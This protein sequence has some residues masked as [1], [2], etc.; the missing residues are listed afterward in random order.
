MIDDRVAIHRYIFLE[1]IPSK[2]PYCI[3]HQL[4]VI[5]SFINDLLLQ[6]FI[7]A[8]HTDTGLSAPK[9]ISLYFV[10]LSLMAFLSSSFVF[11]QFQQGIFNFTLLS[12]TETSCS[13]IFCNPLFRLKK[14][15]IIIMQLCWLCASMHLHS[16]T[17]T[18]EW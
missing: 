15:I 8:R 3:I 5:E 18:C 6:N 13:F 1:H 11:M 2:L 12:P 17:Y 4:S 10:I 7:Q 16:S 9:I 14:S